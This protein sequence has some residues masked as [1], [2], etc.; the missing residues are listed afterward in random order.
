MI[1]LYYKGGEKKMLI[2]IGAGSSCS[3]YFLNYLQTILIGAGI[4][5]IG[6]GFGY[7]IRWLQKRQV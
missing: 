7:F 1:E 3:V 2:I 6:L 5:A 4:L